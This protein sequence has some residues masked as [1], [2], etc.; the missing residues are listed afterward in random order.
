MADEIDSSEE[1]RKVL[2]SMTSI[3]PGL[4]N[5][6][7]LHQAVQHDIDVLTGIWQR[8]QEIKPANDAKLNRLKELLL[9][10][11]KGQK[12]LIF[13]YYKDTA[14]YLYQHLGHPEKSCRDGLLQKA[15]RSEH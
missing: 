13:S 14:R 8:V 5:L 11:L 10:D 9:N 2:E 12:V 3:D 15:W 7:K 1:A 6:R 4:Y